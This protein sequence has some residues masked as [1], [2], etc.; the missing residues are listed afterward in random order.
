MEDFILYIVAALFLL[1]VIYFLAKKVLLLFGFG[2]KKLP[3]EKREFLMNPSEEDFYR[4]LKV[5]ISEEYVVFPQIVLSNIVKV[6]SGQ[7]EFWKYQNK[8]NKKTIDFVIFKKE[9]F[10]PVLAIE[11]D[12]KT[13]QRPERIERDLLV[14]NILESA[15]IASVHI[16]HSNN[17]DYDEII[18][19]IEKL[20]LNKKVQGN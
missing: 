17:L 18:I 2:V 19:K 15:G 5:L 12:G 10:E 9:H 6:A 8:I 3:F 4:E 11:Y 1:L 20:L 7:K 13:H 16:Q 14:K